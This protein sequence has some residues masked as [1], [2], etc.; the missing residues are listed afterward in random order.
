MASLSLLLICLFFVGIS[1]T[2]TVLHQPDGS[3]FTVDEETNTY[4]ET[5][6]KTAIGG[7]PIFLKQQDNSVNLQTTSV[8]VFVVIYFF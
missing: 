5:T 1:G 3:V 7:Y 4:G 2:R 6:F 8:L